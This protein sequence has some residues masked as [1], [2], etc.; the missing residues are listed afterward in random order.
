[1]ATGAVW[2][3][4]VAHMAPTAAPRRALRAADTKIFETMQPVS[5][6]GNEAQVLTCSWS[7]TMGRVCDQH[8]RPCKI[9]IRIGRLTFHRRPK[10]WLLSR[11]ARARR[12]RPPRLWRSDQ[13]HAASVR[14]PTEHRRPTAS[15]VA[16][17]H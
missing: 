13:Q 5:K 17:G 11:P 4:P 12:Y 9:R 8:G 7:P 1:Y 6:S 10:K 2:R 3:T 16:E 15:Q 14:E